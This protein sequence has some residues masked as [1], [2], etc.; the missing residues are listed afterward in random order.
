MI[1]V[2]IEI[3]EEISCDAETVE[4]NTEKKQTKGGGT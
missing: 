4:D 1:T 3:T 2:V